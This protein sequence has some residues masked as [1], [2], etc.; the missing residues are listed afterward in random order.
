MMGNG[1]AFQE[2][3][4]LSKECDPLVFDRKE[5]CLILKE[6]RSHAYDCQNYNPHHTEMVQE[7]SKSVGIWV[8]H[9]AWRY[10][11]IFAAG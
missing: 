9:F 2:S 1:L 5:N 4:D 11:V 7:N 6:I 8:M 3:V 10:Y